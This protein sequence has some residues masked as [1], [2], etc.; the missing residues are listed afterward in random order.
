[1]N[2]APDRRMNLP[3]LVILCALA[4]CWAVPAITV[5]NYARTH[6]DMTWIKKALKLKA[7]K[8]KSLSHY[9]STDTLA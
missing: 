7:D 4:V 3:L 6:L 1:M 8:T 2:V 5:V 9:R